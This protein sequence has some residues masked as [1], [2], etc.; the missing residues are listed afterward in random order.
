MDAILHIAGVWVTF[1]I[2]FKLIADYSESLPFVGQYLYYFFLNVGN[3]F[4]DGTADFSPGPGC[5]YSRTLEFNTWV[6]G[7]VQ[8]LKEILTWDNIYDS[9]LVYLNAALDAWAWVLHAVTHVTD[10]VTN[11][12][13]SVQ[14][15]VQG[16][17]EI[18][19]QWAKDLIDQVSSSVAGLQE[20]WDNFKG[21]IPTLNEVILWWS[22]W[23]AG[24]WSLLDTWWNDRLLDVQ[25]LIDSSFIT[26]LPFY[27][28]LV[29]LWDSIEEFFT[30]PEEWLYNAF[31]RII[32]RFW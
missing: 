10:I 6:G 21:M 7:A 24:V 9:L 11:W 12:W 5:L 19:K 23:R 13:L 30:D 29:S 16:W 28:N 1:S 18:A 14:V 3:W 8:K 20:A 2:L 17:I 27:D 4:Y 15:T 32:E 25:S 31:D 26:W 22:N